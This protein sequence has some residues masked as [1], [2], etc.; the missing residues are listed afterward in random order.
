MLDVYLKLLARI[1]KDNESKREME[2]Q[3]QQQREPRNHHRRSST[4]QIQENLEVDQEQ[5][6]GMSS[7]AAAEATMV[8]TVKKEDLEDRDCGGRG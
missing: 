5:F 8:T 1:R 6:D 3:Q 4:M 2:E 7:T